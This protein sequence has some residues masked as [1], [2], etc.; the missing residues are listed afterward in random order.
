MSRLLLD[1]GNTRL[2]WTVA[3][4]DRG[5]AVLGP[6][7]A[8]G[9]GGPDF[10]P[11][12]AQR[13]RG[14]P[15]LESAHMVSVASAELSSAVIDSVQA[16]ARIRRGR[17]QRVQTQARAGR[18]V[19]AYAEPARLGTD[20][21][22]ALRGAL[23][24]AAPPLLVVNAGTALTLDAVDATGRHLGGLILA[25]IEAMR[26]GLLRRAPHLEVADWSPAAEPFWACDT[27]PALAIAPWQAAAGLVERARARLQT[28]AASVPRLLLAGGD[29][30]ALQGLLEGPSELQSD[31]VLLGLLEAALDPEPGGAG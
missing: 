12:L 28:E 3:D 22:L 7:H 11:S 18:L 23:R 29:A 5:L 16:L 21:W 17:V 30:A 25:G 8:L 26:E 9:H 13:L 20:R 27:G 6:V 19:C 24:L 15:E 14:L 31:L 4:T 2:K 10:L 1:L